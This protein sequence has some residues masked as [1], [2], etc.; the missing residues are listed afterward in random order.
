MSKLSLFCALLAVLSTPAVAE[1]IYIECSFEQCANSVDC[2][3][4]LPLITHFLI[5]TRF[6]K[7]YV[8]SVPV[9]RSVKHRKS[10]KGESLI[11][12]RDN[13]SVFVTTILPAGEAVYSVHQLQTPASGQSAEAA[14]HQYHGVCHTVTRNAANRYSDA[15]PPAQ[16]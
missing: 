15:L 10:P 2:D 8:L 9:A 7:A 11:E 16:N 4:P 13:G 6:N 1:P 5:D 14:F 12:V 3:L